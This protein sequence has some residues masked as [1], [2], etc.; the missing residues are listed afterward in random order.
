MLHLKINKLAS[1]MALPLLGLAIAGC[2][3]GGGGGGGCALSPS[4]SGGP[5]E[6]L[7]PYALL[8]AGLGVPCYV[9]LGLGLSPLVVLPCG[10][11]V[12]LVAFLVVARSTER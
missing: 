8:A 4:D 5:A 12:L 10:L 3:G 9:A 1:I 2:G 11:V 7:L 6:F